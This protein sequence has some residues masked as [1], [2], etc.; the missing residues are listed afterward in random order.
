M[1]GDL[2]KTKTKNKQF[3]IV[4]EE[5]FAQKSQIWI[6]VKAPVKSYEENR[7]PALGFEIGR[8]QV[9]ARAGPNHNR[10]QWDSAGHSLAIQTCAKSGGPITANNSYP[11]QGIITAFWEK[12]RKMILRQIQ[13]Q[14]WLRFC[15]NYSSVRVCIS[16]VIQDGR[17]FAQLLI[18][19]KESFAV[20]F[21]PA[22]GD[23]LKILF[24]CVSNN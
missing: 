12:E 1:Y 6:E 18:T 9:W 23:F 14:R 16:L 20:P 21:A 10:I 24:V 8:R 7:Q 19:G 3:C 13:L 2:E 4:W 22:R 11:K 17:M 15:G 5:A